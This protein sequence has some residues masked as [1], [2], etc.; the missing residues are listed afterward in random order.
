MGQIYVWREGLGVIPKEDA[1]PRRGGGLQIVSDIEP[2]I[3][4]IDRSVIGGR[5]QK[6]DHMRAHGV[7]EVGNERIH[8]KRRP[9][10]E[11]QGV[12]DDVRRAFEQLNR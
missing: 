2:F 11:P 1:P 4:P 8:E 6:R 12:G 3:S 10:Y 9:A 5:A 7:V